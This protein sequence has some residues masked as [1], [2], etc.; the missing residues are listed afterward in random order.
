LPVDDVKEMAQKYSVSEEFVKARAEDVI[1]YCEAKGKTYRDYK[2][3]LR[4]FIKSHRGTSA[5]R[6]TTN[7]L[8]AKEGKYAGYG[9]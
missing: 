3:A 6:K 9:N 8:P 2:A 1:D 4:N 5:G 7:A